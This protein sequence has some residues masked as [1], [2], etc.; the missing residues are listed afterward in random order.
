MVAHLDSP[1]VLVKERKF[2]PSE[3]TF[4]TWESVQDFYDQLLNREIQSSDELYRLMLDKSELDSIIDEEFRKRYVLCTVETSNKEYAENLEFMYT[5]VLPK[6]MPVQFSL[7]QKLVTSPYKSNLQQEQL[8]TFWRSAQTGLELYRDENI[9]LTQE[10]GLLVKKYDEITGELSVEF[11]GEKFSLT[12]AGSF[13]KSQDRKVREEVFDKIQQ[14]RLSVQHSLAELYLE[15][16]AKRSAMAA[17][18]SYSNFTDYQFKSLGRFDYSASDCSQFHSSIEKHVL[19]IVKKIQEE[20][21]KDLKLDSLKPYDLDVEPSGI[22]SF[23]T[24]SSVEDFINQT[25]QCLNKVDVFFSD[26]LTQMQKAGKLDLDARLG[27]ALGGYNMNMPESG[28]P[29]VFMNASLNDADIRVLTHEMG[30]SAHAVLAFHLPLNELRD[31][32]AE[33]SELASMSMELFCLE[34][35]DVF[36]SDEK[37][38]KEAKARYLEGLTQTLVSV[39]LNDAFQHEVYKTVSPTTEG[40][41]LMYSTLHKKYSTG[42]IDYSGYEEVRSIIWQRIPHM[43][44]SPFYYVEYGFAQ[45]G[46]IAMYRNYL[47]DKENTI[48]QYKH[49]LSLGYSKPIPELYKAAGIEFNFSSDYINELMKFL[50]DRIQTLR[51]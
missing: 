22:E 40:L 50:Q 34:N 27:K 23:V 20:R 9:P 17:N 4:S 29:F 41:N 21:I 51:S 14:S 44:H 18:C 33:V 48:N 46:A 1:E 13:L 31:V 43:Y 24:F 12:K 47:S 15:L 3:Y 42:L 39:A 36:I 25:S 16:I 30:H 7:T 26:V 6:W 8:F 38:L 11:N 32:P 28:L 35:W 49:M 45:L 19:P 2:I 10:I 37:V 5:Q